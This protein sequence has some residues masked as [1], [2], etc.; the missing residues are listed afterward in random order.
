MPRRNTPKPKSPLGDRFVL[1]RGRNVYGYSP[2]LAKRRDAQVVDGPYAAAVLLQR[3]MTQHP[4]VAAHG[5]E[6]EKWLAQ[7]EQDSRQDALTAEDVV[8]TADA[9]IDTRK[10]RKERTQTLGDLDGTATH[11]L[12]QD[13]L[14]G[15]EFSAGA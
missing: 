10:N 15:D 12:P 9:V 7:F 6:A 2:Q 4:L 5:K 11:S 8:E 3:G 1:I 13:D 14:F